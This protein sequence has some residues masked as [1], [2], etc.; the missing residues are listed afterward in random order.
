MPSILESDDR[1]VAGNNW[2]G[3]PSKGWR[4]ICYQGDEVGSEPLHK[5]NALVCDAPG[6]ENVTHKDFIFGDDLLQRH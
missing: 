5:F 4:I 1:L 2:S 3:S 6:N